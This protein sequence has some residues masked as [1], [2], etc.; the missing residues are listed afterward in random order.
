MTIGMLVIVVF[1]VVFFPL[2][3]LVIVAVRSGEWVPRAIH[4]VGRRFR[5]GWA[6]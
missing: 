2:T 6:R 1:A 3:L 4:A 5:A